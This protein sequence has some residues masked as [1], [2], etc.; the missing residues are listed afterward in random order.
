M[1][2]VLVGAA[3]GDLDVSPGAVRIDEANQVGRAVAAILVV[4]AAPNS[5][6]WGDGYSG[7]AD[8]LRGALVEADH[9]VVWVGGLGVKLHHILHAGHEVPSTLGRHQI[10]GCQGLISLS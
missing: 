9:R 1:G 4:D 7:L 5:R 3:L 8:Q 10:L 2:E 6:G